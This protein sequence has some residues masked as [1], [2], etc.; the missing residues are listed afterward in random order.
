[1]D[2]SY[3]QLAARYIRR[4]AVQLAK[5]LDGVRAAEDIEFVHRARVATRRLRASLSDVQAVLRPKE[6]QALAEGDP[7]VTKSLGHARDRDVQI[8]CLC[9]A[10]SALNAKECFPGVAHVL[11]Q[12]EH[13]RE[14]FQRQVVKAVDRLEAGGV[15]REMRRATRKALDR[16]VKGTVPF[17][18]IRKLGQSPRIRRP[19][20]LAN[21]SSGTSFGSWKSCFNM[22]A[23]WPIQKTEGITT[24]CELRRSGCGTRWRFRVRYVRGGSTKAWKR[25]R[26]CKRCWATFT[27]AT[28]GWTISTHSPRASANDHHDV[29]ARRP[30]LAFAARHRVSAQGSAGHRQKRSRNLAKYWGELKERRFLD[31]LAGAIESGAGNGARTRGSR[32]RQG[33][34]DEHG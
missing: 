27:I 12:L 17:S 4:Q 1:M 26:D 6:G 11:V 28:S 2:S 20:R 18:L 34:R 32:T 16:S 15:L 7:R 22:K 33:T 8:E 5:Q 31:E 14:R 13:D 21:R 3:Q 30:V 9:G 24:R 29:R 25:S 23:R 10:L 19:P